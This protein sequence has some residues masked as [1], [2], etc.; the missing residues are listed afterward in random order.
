MGLFEISGICSLQKAQIVGGARTGLNADSEISLRYTCAVGAADDVSQWLQTNRK[1]VQDVSCE[2]QKL[3]GVWRSVG[4]EVQN[5]TKDRKEVDVIQTFRKGFIKSLVSGGVVDYSEARVVTARQL[6][7]GSVVGESLAEALDPENYV[8]LRWEGVDPLAIQ[9]VKAQLEGVSATGWSPVARGEAYGSDYFRLVVMATVAEGEQDTDRS[10]TI[11]V[12]L[13]KPRFNL[14]MWEQRG[15]PAEVRVYKLLNVPKIIAQSVLN[16]Y[17]RDVNY[18]SATSDGGS[19]DGLYNLTISTPA[20]DAVATSIVTADACTTKSTTYYFYNQSAP[21]AVPTPTSGVWYS[22]GQWSLNG[23]GVWNGFYIKHEEN[24]V[25]VAQYASVQSSA[26][27]ENSEH[28]FG[29]R[30]GDVDQNGNAV[31]I[32]S[33]AVVVGKVKRLSRRKRNNCTQDVSYEEAVPNN[34][35]GSGSTRGHL[36]WVDT[37]TKTHDVAA[38]TPAALIIGEYVLQSSNPTEVGTFSTVAST[39]QGQKKTASVTFQTRSGTNAASWRTVTRTLMYNYTE[40]DFATAVAALL[41]TMDNKVIG[42][43]MNQYG[44]VD[45]VIETSTVPMAEVDDDGNFTVPIFDVDNYHVRSDNGWW[46]AKAEIAH[47]A[48]AVT[49][50]RYSVRVITSTGPPTVPHWIKVSSSGSYA[51]GY[52]SIGNGIWKA[53]RVY[54]WGVR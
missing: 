14:E 32:P 8:L 17:N 13:A 25:Y 23:N 53:V 35:D 5:T 43:N 1:T 12:I 39:H 45:G 48:D 40:A 54:V 9:A 47:F 51:T 49:A 22:N 7:A 16:T 10:G 4:I 28:H 24:H 50:L 19:A 52:S 33:M 41:R 31:A 38:L 42:P 37:A 27:T 29:V 11:D 18:T 26:L 15:S 30:D 6:P 34:Q 21:V 2:F 46:T 36:D 3:E 44:L 20:L